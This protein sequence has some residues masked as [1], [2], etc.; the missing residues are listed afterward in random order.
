MFA[1]AKSSSGLRSAKRLVMVSCGMTR[2]IN[3]ELL[4]MILF[5]GFTRFTASFRAP[6]GLNEELPSPN[7]G[8]DPLSFDPW[9]SPLDGPPPP[10]SRDVLGSLRLS[11]NLVL[12][13]EPLLVELLTL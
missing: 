13:K 2:K 6:A 3:E 5:F 7:A 4:L 9:S 1:K 10:V 12:D 8:A 11:L